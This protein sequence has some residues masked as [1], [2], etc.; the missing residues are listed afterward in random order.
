MQIR[1]FSLSCFA[2][3]ARAS[4]WMILT[5]RGL[6]GA[7]SKSSVIALVRSWNRCLKSPAE[8]CFSDQPFAYR[9]HFPSLVALQQSMMEPSKAS[10]RRF[11]DELAQL[12]SASRLA[13]KVR[14]TSVG[15]SH[16]AHRLPS[17]NVE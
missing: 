5:T 7:V 14:N 10:F 15:N 12:F 2:T 4:P 9:K 13:S 8:D 3:S 1:N 6:I 16:R 17:V 11:R